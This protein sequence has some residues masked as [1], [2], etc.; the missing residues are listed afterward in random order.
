MPARAPLSGNHLSL[1]LMNATG[2]TTP[3]F[4]FFEIVQIVSTKDSLADIDRK[5]G[6]VLGMSKNENGEWGYA[7]DVYEDIACTD[8]IDGWDIDEAHLVKT[9]RTMNPDDIY[10]GSTI[11]VS[12]DGH[13]K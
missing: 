8:R 13:E 6:V 10:D 1:P 4:S 9:G 3:L 2:Q 11:H 7:V 5:F 12:S